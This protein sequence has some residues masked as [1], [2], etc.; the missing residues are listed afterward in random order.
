M[1]RWS[2]HRVKYLPLVVAFALCVFL[3]Q[4]VA[5]TEGQKTF[6]T[7]QNATDAL[8]SAVRDGNDAELQAILGAGSDDI[9]SSGDEVADKAAG[10]KFVASYDTKHSLVKSGSNEMTLNVGKDDWP[11]P[12]PLVQAQGKWYFDGAAGKEE[13]LYRRIGHNELDA[14]KTCKGVVAAQKDYAAEG[15][16]GQAPGSYATRFLSEPGK[17]NGLYWEAQE[18]EEPS[19]AGPF[20]ARASAE[21]Y[22]TSGQKTPYH[23][24]YYR[25]LTAQGS[26]ARGGAKSYIENGRMTGGFALIAY[27]A[28]YRSSGVTTFFVNQDGQIYQKDLGEKTEELASQTSEYNPDKTWQLV[29]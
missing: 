2:K 5:Q 21:G 3:A 24:Y 26:S 23:G 4:G 15:H 28:D 9:I 20:L 1:T 17:R 25:L 18:G 27:P 11:L 10:Q 12:I 7:A 6:T 16:D 8:I 19:P 29:K 14:I 22:D 13:I